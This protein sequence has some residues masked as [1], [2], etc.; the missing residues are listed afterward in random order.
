MKD[1]STFRARFPAL[2]RSRYFM[3]NSLGAMPDTVPAAMAEMSR[4]WVEKGADAWE[5]WVPL[6][7]RVADQLGRLMGAP[8][9][10]V[11]LHLN[12]SS[13]LAQLFSCF[14]FQGSKRNRI[15]CTQ[16]DF[17]TL[18]YL[19]DTWKAYGAELVVVPS[20]DGIGVRTTDLLKAID[21]R[22]ALVLTCQVFFGSSY[23]QDLEP[24]VRHAH[25]HGARVCADVYQS[26]GAVPIDVTKLQVDFAIGGSHKYLC[27]GTGAGFLYVRPDLLASL[28]PRVT[29]WLSHADAFAMRVEPMRWAEG[30]QRWMGGTPA[31]APLYV[32]PCGYSIIE[33]I[34]L[35]AIRENSL[36][37]TS[38]LLEHA[39]RLK[40]EV[41][42]P[43]SASE[44]GGSVHVRFAGVERAQGWLRE[45]GFQVHY[46]ESYQGLRISPHF[47]NT[48][49]EIDELM[50]AIGQL[51]G[52]TRG[53]S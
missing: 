25:K 13:L 34:G 49:G 45:R 43:R 12:T 38:R 48:L 47:Y 22:T 29:G 31:V 42:S 35:A 41:R 52:E 18:A 10:S 46:R 19:A 6:S 37:Q 4:V 15:V 53:H 5:D 20:H 7:A 3:T 33:E 26:I 17:P 50:N 14:D 21:E 24:V 40:L 51:T 9:G 2:Q 11:A 27:G 30:M 16:M 1:L 23:L 28:E 32:A 39:D 44:R 36:A 8:A